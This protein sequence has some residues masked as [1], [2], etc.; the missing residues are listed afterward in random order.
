MKS[1]HKVTIYFIFY[2]LAFLAIQFI[3]SDQSGSL[4]ITGPLHIILGSMLM[5]CLLFSLFAFFMKERSTLKPLLI[6]GI[7][8]QI[9][10][11]IILFLTY[12]AFIADDSHVY[13]I[14][15][16][17]IVV[18]TLIYFFTPKIKIAQ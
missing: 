9:W 11:L 18:G 12:G 4:S 10:N 6:F 8:L 7:I 2:F 1:Q 15:I 13:Y 14:A 16:P 3:I 17:Q 5:S